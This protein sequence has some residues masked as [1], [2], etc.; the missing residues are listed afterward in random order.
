M[1]FNWKLNAV[2]IGKGERCVVGC[3]ACHSRQWREL[4]TSERGITGAVEVAYWKL[5]MYKTMDLGWKISCSVTTYNRRVR[6][7]QWL[8]KQFSSHP[9]PPSLYL[10]THFLHWELLS[11]DMACACHLDV[12][13]RWVSGCGSPHDNTPSHLSILGEIGRCRYRCLLPHPR[14]LRMP[15]HQTY[16]HTMLVYG[17]W[18]LETTIRLKYLVGYYRFVLCGLRW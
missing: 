2:N 17:D 1:K 8:C 5:A 15:S 4:L 18:Y 10:F 11:V 12:M 16:S 7:V 14:E 9:N 6:A 13:G 3:S